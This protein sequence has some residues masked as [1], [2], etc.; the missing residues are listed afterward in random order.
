MKPR[1][2]LALLM[3][4]LGMPAGRVLAYEV[5]EVQNGRREIRIDERF[6][7]KVARHDEQR[8]R[9]QVGR[10][11][12]N[13]QVRSRVEDRRQTADRAQRAAASADQQEGNGRHQRR[14]RRVPAPCQQDGR[15]RRDRAGD[16]RADPRVLCDPPRDATTVRAADER[17]AVVAGLIETPPESKVTALPTSPSTG[18]VAAAGS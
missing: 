2:V 17:Q 10:A 4:W 6:R 16:Q 14:D 3:I 12:L 11:K 8:G 7:P 5:S 13:I 9:E 15:H 18:P 1:I